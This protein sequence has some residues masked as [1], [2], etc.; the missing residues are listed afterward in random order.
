MDAWILKLK[1]K[2]KSKG[3]RLMAKETKETT[4]NIF[5]AEHYRAF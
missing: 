3:Q 1:K 4:A 2:K 5:R